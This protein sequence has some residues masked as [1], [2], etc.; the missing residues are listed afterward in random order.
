MTIKHL[1]ISKNHKDFL[2]LSGGF[3][4]SQ[5]INKKAQVLGYSLTSL[6]E[7]YFKFY[8]YIKQFVNEIPTR[9]K[10]NNLH[11]WYPLAFYDPKQL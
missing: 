6:L 8:L 10:K 11:N 3:F 9:D 2:Y 7:T 5:I 4:E 1:G